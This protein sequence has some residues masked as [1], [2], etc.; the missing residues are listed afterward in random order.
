M[1]PAWHVV[2]TEP[3]AEV[4]A[5]EACIAAGFNAYCPQYNVTEL[6]YKKKR[7]RKVPFIKNYLFVQCHG[8]NAYVWH[9]VRALSGVRTFLGGADPWIV[10]EDEIGELRKKIGDDG[11]FLSDDL[12]RR[13]RKFNP[14]DKIKLVEGAFKDQIAICESVSLDGLF[15]GVK[16]SLLGQE[17][18]VNVP[19]A[20]CDPDFGENGR[21]A[22]PH[23]RR[24]RRKHRRKSLA[25]KKSNSV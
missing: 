23:G 6:R 4:K 18:T 5:S 2:A 11:S 8:T 15:A 24:A 10:R 16:I 21:T 14:G 25:A 1:T 3:Q 13:F 7:Q 17:I 12:R 9:Q 19:S 20:L 22:M